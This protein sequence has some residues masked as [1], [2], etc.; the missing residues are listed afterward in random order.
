M[1]KF[2][3][4]LLAVLV[5]FSMFS[6]VVSAAD[7][8]TLTLSADKTTVKA[9]DTVKVTV[10]VPENSGLAALTVDVVYDATA[11]EAVSVVGAGLFTSQAAQGMEMPN[12]NY[13][14]GKAR[15]VAVATNALVAG[16]TVFTAEFK[17]LTDAKSTISL[18]VSESAGDNGE[19][20]VTANSVV[21]N[22][23][24]VEEPTE[25]KH[26][27]MSNWAVTKKA[28]C[29]KDGVETRNC[30]VCDYSETK[31]IPATGE[32][33]YK[34]VV[35]KEATATQYGEK[36]LKC[37]MCGDV[38]ETQKLAVKG[39]ESLTNPAIPNTDAIA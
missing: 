34:W 39:E 1:K 22:E 20:A 16:G 7:A 21:I 33:S 14:A 13:A 32:C 18:D 25:C 28:T 9:G 19:I 15:F 6:F 38:K 36:Q 5:A 31:A 35:T 29:K 12:A 24:T 37:T 30:T 26:E 23:K 8:T 4:V 3:S 27:T 2:A 10:S 17:A 11:F